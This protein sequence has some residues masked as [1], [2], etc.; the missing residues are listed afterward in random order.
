MSDGY[1]IFVED[2][3]SELP[4]D[5]EL[6]LTIKDLAPG[7]RKYNNRVVKAL[8]AR[9]PD[10]LPGA[11]PLTVRSWTGRIISRSY[12]IKVLAELAPTL[13]GTPHGETLRAL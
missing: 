8:V 10:K 6:I 12:F 11:S 1:V 2:V 3:K 9:A 4:E 7:P 5:R 13:P